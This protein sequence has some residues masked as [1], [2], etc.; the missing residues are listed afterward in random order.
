MYTFHAC[1]HVAWFTVDHEGFYPMAPTQIIVLPSFS[2]A[3]LIEVRAN[4]S[5][6]LDIHAFSVFCYRD[7]LK[8]ILA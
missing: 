4:F 5:Q 2:T 3:Y 1:S 8:I 7:D 6:W